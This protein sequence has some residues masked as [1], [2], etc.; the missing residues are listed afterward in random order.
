MDVNA[1]NKEL[2]RRFVRRMSVLG[3]MVYSLL[4]KDPPLPESSIFYGT[5]FTENHSLEN[6]L[7]SLPAAS[8]LHFQTSI[9]PSAV[10]QA[11][12]AMERPVRNYYPLAGEDFLLARLCIAGLVTEEG[13]VY[14]VAGEEQGGWLL[15]HGIASPEDWAIVL[16]LDDPGKEGAIGS[17]RWNPEVTAAARGSQQNIIESVRALTNYSPQTLASPMGSAVYVEWNR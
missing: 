11:M 9:H 3:K 2:P 15:D 12:I 7:K 8:P 10:Q 17:I 1:V 13:P 16:Q 5:A 4:R 14:L 6:Y